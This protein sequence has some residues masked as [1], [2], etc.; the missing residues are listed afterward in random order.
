MRPSGER[1][2]RA[3]AQGQTLWA[4]AVPAPTH[5]SGLGCCGPLTGEDFA[6]QCSGLS[7][8]TERWNLV[9]PS[10][11]EG[12][13]SPFPPSSC[14][15]RQQAISQKRP[16]HGMGYYR[17]PMLIPISGAVKVGL[18]GSQE[19]QFIY[20]NICRGKGQSWMAEGHWNCVWVTST[21]PERLLSIRYQWSLVSLLPGGT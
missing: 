8:P 16:C 14:S 12:C 17:L 13:V 19:P 4:G 18:A 2:F 9:R 5:T 3:T 7:V 1:Y 11:T 15:G 6:T 20:P 21:G 10:T